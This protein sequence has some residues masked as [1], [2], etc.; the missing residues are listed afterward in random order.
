MPCQPLG[1]SAL[2][3]SGMTH[4]W[5]PCYP[6]PRRAL[7]LQAAANVVK[8]SLTFLDPLPQILIDDTQLWHVRDNQSGL[9]VEARDTLSPPRLFARLLRYRALINAGISRCTISC[10]AAVCMA[11][12]VSLDKR[13]RSGA[14]TF[15]HRCAMRRD[16]MGNFGAPPTFRSSH[17]FEP[18]GQPKRQ[19]MGSSP[20]RWSRN[21]GW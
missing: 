20:R 5:P 10:A 15:R 2:W 18:I 4:S 13:T 3:R 16:V 21:I 8:A 12:V 14:E 19:I 1:V 9:F 7:Q 6:R 17:A 11:A